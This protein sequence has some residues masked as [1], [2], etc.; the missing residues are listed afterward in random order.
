MSLFAS[1]VSHAYSPLA[2]LAT[3]RATYPPRGKISKSCIDIIVQR[4]HVHVKL[5]IS[6]RDNLCPVPP[7]TA[8]RPVPPRGQFVFIGRSLRVRCE[9]AFYFWVKC[10]FLLIIMSHVTGLRRRFSR[11]R[12]VIVRKRR[13]H[14]HMT[15]M[16]ASAIG[17]MSL[18]Y[19]RY[20]IYVFRSRGQ[21]LGTSVTVSMGYN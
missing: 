3:A 5:F 15:R 4:M 7:S 1:K 10:E 11:I 14:I 17:G 12:T 9:R 21:R 6:V 19:L 20:N 18:P 16:F 2:S 13:K 8:T